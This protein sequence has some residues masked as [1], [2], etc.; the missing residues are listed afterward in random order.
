MKHS[1]N[2]FTI[3]LEVA[4]DEKYVDNPVDLWELEA[5]IEGLNHITKAK[6][7]GWKESQND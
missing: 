4:L 1:F 3:T 7:L 5:A 6:T 2:K